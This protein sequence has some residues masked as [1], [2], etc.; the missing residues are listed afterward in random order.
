MDRHLVCVYTTDK[1]KV[2]R[3]EDHVHLLKF[4][5]MASS[6][7]VETTWSIFF[8]DPAF[9]QPSSRAPVS[10][11]GRGENKQVLLGVSTHASMHTHT[12]PKPFNSLYTHCKY[13]WTF[14]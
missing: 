2:K 9:S 11:M 14:N 7:R 3:R 12:Q 10:C 5:S 1:Y 6:L 4:S 13:M 8:V